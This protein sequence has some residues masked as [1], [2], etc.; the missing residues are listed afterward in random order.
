M[1]L[2][3]SELLP[4]LKERV[5]DRILEARPFDEGV[6]ASIAEHGKLEDGGVLQHA[7]MV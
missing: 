6:R 2:L 4:S 3:V 5:V 1:A 7:G